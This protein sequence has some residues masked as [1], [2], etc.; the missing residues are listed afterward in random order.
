VS[1]PGIW[2]VS[3]EVVEEVESGVAANVGKS[4]VCNV[5][6]ASKICKREM[7]KITTE[8]QKRKKGEEEEEERGRITDIERE[9]GPGCDNIE[10]K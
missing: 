5:L 4:M 3:I 9:S 6:S 8:K 7:K 2:H 10:S 1:G